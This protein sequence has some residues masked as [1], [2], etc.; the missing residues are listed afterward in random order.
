L[1]H[2]AIGISYFITNLRQLNE[3]IRCLD[4]VYKHVYK[5]YLVNGRYKEFKHELDYSV[6]GTTQLL[7][8]R[9]PN[10]EV[11]NCCATQLVKRQIYLEMAGE[12]K[13]DYL[14]VMDSD[15]FV[16]PDFSDWTGFYKELEQ[17]YDE[18][19][20]LYF[21][22]FWISKDWQCSANPV[23]METWQKYIRIHK[24]PGS[25]KYHM[26]H[27]TWR[28]KDDYSVNLNSLLCKKTLGG[29]KLTCDSMYRDEDFLKRKADWEQSDY[30][31]EQ[32]RVW[33]ALNKLEQLSNVVFINKT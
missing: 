6:E 31:Q 33:V 13:C 12:D 29:I 5:I 18:E 7:K 4:S 32:S 28:M 1:V 26:N 2:L 23:V 25:Q 24:N 17:V 3:L 11:V 8:E 9:Y 14:L 27:Y 15:D 20:M 21:L 10:V 16:H 19:E 22:W 30:L